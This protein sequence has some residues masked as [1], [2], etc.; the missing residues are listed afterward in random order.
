MQRIVLS[1][2]VLSLLISCKSEEPFEIQEPSENVVWNLVNFRS[3]IPGSDNFYS[4]NFPIG[5]KSF[6]F[7]D[8]YDINSPHQLEMVMTSISDFPFILPYHWESD[9]YTYIITEGRV[10]IDNEQY[11]YY[12][13]DDHFYLFRD[14]FDYGPVLHFVKAE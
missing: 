13:E 10:Y 6:D 2:I 4:H 5:E 7:H 12:L 3:G 8:F 1:F 14:H 9:F 11:E